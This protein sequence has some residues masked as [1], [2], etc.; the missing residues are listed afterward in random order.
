MANDG[1][2]LEQ[3]VA[4]VEE[5]LLPQGF[6]VKTN[7]RVLNDE[8]V[9]IAEF[10]VEVRGKV[11]TMN[12]AWLI[13][14]RDR[15]GHGPAPGAWIEQ[16]YG[17]RARFGFNKVTAVST[18]G[19]AVGA[20]DFARSNGIELREVAALTPEAFGSWLAVRGLVRA[21]RRTQLARATL[22]LMD[23]ESEERKRAI[24]GLFTA[25]GSEGLHLRATKSG[26]LHSLREVFLF[27]VEFKGDMFDGLR[28][29]GPSKA[30]HFRVNYT[31]DEDHFVLETDNGPAR[32]K[33]IDFRGDLSIIESLV[34]L[35]VTS[36]YRSIDTGE[37]ISQVA[38]FAPM[39]VHGSQLSVELHRLEES[40]ETHVIVR[41]VGMSP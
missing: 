4:F 33:A 26:A 3:L 9:Q 36:E 28:P 39:D 20:I 30:V 37:R 31:N 24:D 15:P 25:L 8:G 23:G 29:N 16:L 17:R 40:G 41:R 1:K 35:E 12:V 34:P 6:E 27:A 22:S 18:T 32:V 2:Q 19:F 38:A 10:D 14:C 13:E 11:G 21:E 7:E 5:T